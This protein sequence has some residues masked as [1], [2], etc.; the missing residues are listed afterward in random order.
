MESIFP[1]I[2]KSQPFFNQINNTTAAEFASSAYLVTWDSIP[3]VWEWL[4]SVVVERSVVCALA[5]AA[6]QSILGPDTV[7]EV[8]SIG[9]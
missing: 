9:V 4:R 1:Y 2:P 6:C 7:A 5:P 8:A 3:L